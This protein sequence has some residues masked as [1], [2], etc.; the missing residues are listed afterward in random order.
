MWMAATDVIEV[1][2]DDSG[3]IDNMDGGVDC[4]V[5]FRE[6]GGKDG[7]KVE[8]RTDIGDS[9]S[10]LKTFNFSHLFPFTFH[11]H[12]GRLNHIYYLSYAFFPP[13]YVCY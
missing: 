10:L 7:V 6:D 5:D 13:V 4:D 1:C 11:T 8:L 9:L 12:T 2:D 3:K